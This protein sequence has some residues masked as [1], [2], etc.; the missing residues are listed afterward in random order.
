VVHPEGNSGTTSYLF[1][2]SLSAPSSQTV[3]VQVATSNGTATAPSDYAAIPPTPLTFASGETSKT[4][5]VLVNGDLIPESDESFAVILSSATNAVIGNS[6]GVGT[7]INDDFARM[8]DGKPDGGGVS[9]DNNWM[10]ATN[11]VGDVAPV[12]GDNLFFPALPGQS[13]SVATNN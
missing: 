9:A 2:V 11:W 10:T 8:W 12:A 5:P 7:I 1:T 4:I 13:G 3:T 6:T